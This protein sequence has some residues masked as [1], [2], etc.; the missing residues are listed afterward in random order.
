[1]IACPHEDCEE[2]LEDRRAAVAH[3]VEQH[4]PDL[5]G[6]DVEYQTQIWQ[7]MANSVGAAPPMPATRR[8]RR[9]LSR[10]DSDDEEN[11]SDPPF[12]LSDADDP[13]EPRSAGRGRPRKRAKAAEPAAKGLEEADDD[14]DD[15]A[16]PSIRR[17]VRQRTRSG[18]RAAEPAGLRRFPGFG[19]AAPSHPAEAAEAPCTQE[20]QV[21]SPRHPPAAASTATVVVDSDD[22]VAAKPVAQSAA[23]ASADRPAPSAKAHL[24]PELLSDSDDATQ[25]DADAPAPPAKLVVWSDSW[26]EK[27]GALLPRPA[28]KWRPMV[29]G[30]EL[31]HLPH[32]FRVLL[33]I[34]AL[35]ARDTPAPALQVDRLL[36]ELVPTDYE[37]VN[38]VVRTQASD[39]AGA[40][41]RRLPTA[42]SNPGNPGSKPAA[43]PTAPTPYRPARKVIY[44]KERM[45]E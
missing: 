1:M 28:G 14:D 6:E 40:E 35:L 25:V 27:A 38:F 43:T 5:A 24:E 20:S 31:E 39:T 9:R 22:E 30:A 10:V 37:R 17:P 15:F 16:T 32:A 18:S 26:P 36:A 12:R 42:A 4:M 33:R 7:A 45:N 3:F 41:P 13:P 11:E 44:K 8:K 2:E 23:P 34:Q 29:D 21:I 19:A